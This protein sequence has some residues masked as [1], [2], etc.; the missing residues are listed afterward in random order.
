MNW[1]IRKHLRIKIISF[2]SV[3]YKNTNDLITRSQ[4]P[5]DNPSNGKDILVNTYINAN[6]SYV[7]G[8]ELV[9]RNK[10]TKWWDIT[11]NL[12]LYTSKIELNDPAQP[13]QDPFASWFAKLNNTFKLPKNFTFRFPV[14]TNP[15]PIFLPVEVIRGGGRGGF[16]GGG[17]MFGQATSSQGYIRANYGV[18][19]ALRFEFMKE[20]KASLSLNIN[21]I[22]RTTQIR[23]SFRIGIF[24]SGCFSPARCADGATEFQLE[25][26]EIRCFAFQTKESKKSIGWFRECQ[27]GSIAV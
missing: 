4:G 10:L 16:G 26:W 9:S 15:R 13:D 7:T 20:R 27:Y 12:N 3:Y 17:G 25:V 18:D 21:D 24:Y 1:H 6:S 11:S 23:C 14:N 2:A 5:G 8:L 19:A 22:F